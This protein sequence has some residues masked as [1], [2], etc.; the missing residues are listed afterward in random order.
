MK[1]GYQP[2]LNVMYGM[3]TDQIQ[4]LR[5]YLNE[6]LAKGFICASRLPAY[7]QVLFVKKPGGRLK[8]YVD[9]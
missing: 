1:D 5:Q 2:P 6:N 3:S 4:E 8:F 7:F 9:Y